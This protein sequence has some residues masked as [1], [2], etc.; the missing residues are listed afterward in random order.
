MLATLELIREAEQIA[1]I[2]ERLPVW[3]AVPLYRDTLARVYCQRADFDCFQRLPLMAKPEMR[4]NF[5]QNFLPAG[6]TVEM[7]LEKNL[8]ELEHTSGTSA[9]RLPVIFARGWWNAQEERAL[10]LNGLVAKVLDEH[11][12]ARR[13]TITSPSCNGLTCPTVWMSRDQRTIGNALFVNLARIPFLISEA[14]LLHMAAEVADWSPQFLDV[15]PVHGARFALY[16]EQHGLKFP[17]LKFI[18]CSYEFVSVVHRKILTRVFG[19]PI[20]NL[21]GS[22]ET[23]HLLMENERSEMKPSYDT[24]FFEIVD[25]DARGIGDLVITTLTNDYMPLLRYRIGDLAERHVQPYENHYTVHGRAR[26]ALAARDGQR[27]T[28]WQVDQCFIEAGGIAHYELRQDENGGCVL[29]FVPDGA[30]PTERELRRVTVRLEA[31]LQLSAEIKTE[32][33]PVLVPAASG[34]FR[35]TCRVAANPPVQA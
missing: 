10:R 13:A 4:N 9:E 16:C 25:V 12:Y 5:P 1:Q 29:R 2:E 3:R 31:L 24:A 32:A 28:T 21:Y 15:D 19:V 11:P 6:Q 17:S 22:T 20:F 33:M 34:K 27:V 18:L 14:E 26:D 30:G 35:L 23:G 8:I 7:L